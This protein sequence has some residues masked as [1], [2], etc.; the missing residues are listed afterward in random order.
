MDPLSIIEFYEG[1]VSEQ[2]KVGVYGTLVITYKTP[3]VVNR[4]PVT[5]SLALGEGVACNT[6]FS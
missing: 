6:I 5:V 2:G 1:K 4:K 3:F